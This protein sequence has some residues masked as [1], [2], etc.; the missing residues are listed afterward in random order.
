MK[1]NNGFK[2]FHNIFSIAFSIKKD[3]RE[4][5]KAFGLSE[6]EARFLFFIGLGDGERKMEELLH[7]FQKHKSTVHQK[8]TSL[9]KKG[10]IVSNSCIDD[11]REKSVA[12]TPQGKKL[13]HEILRVNTDYQK[14]VLK[15]LSQ[16]E[17]VR[18]LLLLEK[19]YS[20]IK[21]EYEK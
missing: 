6:A 9:E 16:E 14:E 7:F 18:L 1:I 19:M 20:G 4:R 17:R 11:K 8:I 15:N 10:F 12:F 21:Q 5:V 3:V 2:I 13:F